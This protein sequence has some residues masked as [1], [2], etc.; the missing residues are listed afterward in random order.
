VQPGGIVSGSGIYV[1]SSA[2]KAA[3]ELSPEEEVYVRPLVFS[4][5]ID[6]FHLASA[7]D[8]YLLYIRD[9]LDLSRVPHLAAYLQRF[10]PI[11][12]RRA[13]IAR[14]AQRRSW[15]ALTWPREPSVFEQ[16]KLLS[17]YRAESNTFCYDESGV[18]VL[19]GTTLLTAKDGVRENLKYFLALLNS[20]VLDFW[21]HFKDKRKGKIREYFYKPLLSVPL[22]RIDF[23]RPD[24]VALHDRLVELV[25]DM[26]AA[27]RELAEYSRYFLEERL[28]RLRESDPL[29]PLSRQRVAAEIQ[30]TVS[31]LR[32]R[33]ARTQTETDRI[34]SDLYGLGEEDLSIIAR[35]LG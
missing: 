21:F 5:A 8:A 4:Q 33:M 24:E 3:L 1:L 13:E 30:A 32:Q 27:Q 34:V 26:I 9:D 25:D 6:R 14:N 12:E 19:K 29:P 20:R 15:Y 11:L 18:Y 16:P 28:T 17:P 7:D 23:D 35:E 22:R 10:R 31:D 2:E